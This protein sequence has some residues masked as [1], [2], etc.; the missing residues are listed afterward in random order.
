MR[1]RFSTS[2][3]EISSRDNGFYDIVAR[4]KGYFK[5]ITL[6]LTLTFIPILTLTLAQAVMWGDSESASM[7][8]SVQA[9]KGFT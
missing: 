9:R 1:T 6:T 2:L 7:N 5:T 3:A 8:T 4:W